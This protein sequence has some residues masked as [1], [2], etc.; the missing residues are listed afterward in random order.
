MNDIIWTYKL[1]PDLPKIPEEFCNIDLDWTPENKE[2]HTTGVGEKTNQPG[3]NYLCA[4]PERGKHVWFGEEVQFG[5]HRRRPSHPGFES[6]VKHNIAEDF[7]DVGIQYFTGGPTSSVHT[8][9][10]RDYSLIY[11]LETGGPDACFGIWQHRDPGHPTVWDKHVTFFDNNELINVATVKPQAGEWY[12]LNAKILHSVTG[13]IK[14]RVG[15]HVS[16]N[17]DPFPEVPG[18]HF[19]RKSQ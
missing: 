7:L 15:L 13:C 12:L 4:M 1:L 18:T 6:W 11:L 17:H 16:L 10:S 8:D 14:S 3:N 2:I 9:I 19:I 5:T